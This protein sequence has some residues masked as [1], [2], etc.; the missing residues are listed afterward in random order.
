MYNSSFSLCFILSPTQNK[1]QKCTK[2]PWKLHCKAAEGEAS[3][4]EQLK[5]ALYKGLRGPLITL[6][7]IAMCRFPTFICC[8]FLSTMHLIPSRE[9]HLVA[10]ECRQFYKIIHNI[11]FLI[12]QFIYLKQQNVWMYFVIAYMVSFLFLALK[13]YYIF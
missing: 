11:F 9:L 2:F 12:I 8:F 3:E 4:A 13:M 1:C 5:M 7:L 10:S 6:L